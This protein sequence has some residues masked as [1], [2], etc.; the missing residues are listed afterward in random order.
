MPL[1]QQLGSLPRV[2]LLGCEFL[3]SPFPS[4]APLCCTPSSSLW[5][6]Q[7]PVATKGLLG[8]ARARGCPRMEP[9]KSWGSQQ[10]AGGGTWTSNR[11]VHT[12][13]PPAAVCPMGFWP[14]FQRVS[15]CLLA[16]VGGCS[17]STPGPRGEALG[18]VLA[19]CLV[20]CW[21]EVLQ[22]SL[23][24]TR[25]GN[26]ASRL[27]TSAL[28]VPEQTGLHWVC[29]FCWVLDTGTPLWLCQGDVRCHMHSEGAC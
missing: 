5:P 15:H 17:P 14:S 26:W 23:H 4:S 27:H 28:L 10:V 2:H 12:Q 20:S 24:S 7:P 13:C 25:R 16:E 21:S 11:P 29:C 1:R 19:L 9:C 22:T 3:G 8:P 18:D 6:Q